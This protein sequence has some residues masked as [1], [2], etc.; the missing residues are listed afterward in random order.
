MNDKEFFIGIWQVP[1]ATDS[2]YKLLSECKINSVFLNGDFAEDANEEKKAVELA[3]KYGIDV[4]LEGHN[5]IEDSAILTSPL[6]EEKAV[7]CFNLF[8]EP[9]Y[10]HEKGLRELALKVKGMYPNKQTYINLNPSYTPDTE[11]S[12]DYPRYMDTFAKLV[13]DVEGK[14]GWLSMDFYPLRRT[15][16]FEYLICE[17]WFKDIETTAKTAKK[18]SLKSHFFI[19][20]MAFGG[21]RYYWCDRTPTEADLRFQIYTYL[22]HGAKGFTHFCYQ[23]PTTD[24]FYERQSGLFD[25]GQPTERWFF[26]QKIHGEVKA[27]ENELLSLDWQS[28]HRVDST[29]DENALFNRENGFGFGEF[30]TIASVESDA[31]LVVGAFKGKDGKEGLVLVNVEETTKNKAVNLKLRFK[32]PVSFKIYKKG[33]S[34]VENFDT[35][36]QIT[37]EVGEGIFMIEK[38]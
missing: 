25:K 27:F 19:Q 12:S 34:L 29:K 23:T 2:N 6:T 36:M 11:V 16:E 14:G 26:A 37:L 17:D 35:Q 5:K 18:Y 24:E 4:V 33:E 22:A 38:K 1:P 15:Q 21:S 20:S 30:A 9:L 28:V 31:R 7:V 8:D 10:R 32:K 13:Y 3:E